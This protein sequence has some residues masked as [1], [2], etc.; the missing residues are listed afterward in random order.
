MNALSCLCHIIN[1]TKT[2]IL[3]WKHQENQWVL[4]IADQ[5]FLSQTRL[6]KRG[7]VYWKFKN[8]DEPLPSNENN[9]SQPAVTASIEKGEVK[10]EL[11]GPL[12]P[13]PLKENVK[14]S[15]PNSESIQ[16]A[17]SN[18]PDSPK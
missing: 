11:P 6:D 16:S 15:E 1:S 9:S 5:K 3:M 12:N 7:T 18:R 8:W 2:P 10:V 14:Q 4:K 13:D 17:N